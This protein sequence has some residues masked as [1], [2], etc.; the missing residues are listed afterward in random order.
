MA[1]GSGQ[2][3]GDSNRSSNHDRSAACT[4]SARAGDC[5]GVP[6]VQQRTKTPPRTQATATRA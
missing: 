1:A 3:Q 5:L 2:Y 6:V 4:C